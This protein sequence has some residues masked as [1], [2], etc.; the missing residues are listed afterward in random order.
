MGDKL[1]EE[2]SISTI[3]SAIRSKLGTEQTYKVGDMATAISSIVKPNG[4]TNIIQN[5]YHDV[6]AYEQAY[7][8]VPGSVPTGTK[9]ITENGDYNVADYASAHVAVPQPVGKKTVTANGTDIDIAQYATLDVAVQPNVDEKTIT[10]NGTYNASSDNLDGYSK[11]VV[12]TPVPTGKKTVTQNETNIDISSYALLDVAV[13]GPNLG[14]KPITENGTYNAS[15]DN[16]DGYSSVSV[17]VPQPSGT[18]NILADVVAKTVDVSSYANAYVYNPFLDYIDIIPVELEQDETSITVP[19][20]TQ[21][22]FEA[23]SVVPVYFPSSA[24]TRKRNSFSYFAENRV[25]VSETEYLKAIIYNNDTPIE[26]MATG[27]NAPSPIF[28]TVNGTITITGRNIS[29]SWLAGTILFVIIYYR[30][31][32]PS[33]G[34]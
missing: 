27:N 13:P 12:S 25:N 20:N 9:N 24:E 18:V 31:N 10:T 15:S 1:Y 19:Y 26:G 33:Q 2:N 30:L 28:D 34:I 5:G 11:V 17:T 8:N 32:P 4:T 29:Y 14:T 23:V 6:T 21:K 22:D 16:L 3:A 7:V